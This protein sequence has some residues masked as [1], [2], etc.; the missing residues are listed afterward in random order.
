ME[1]KLIEFL[2]RSDGDGSGDGDGVL[3]FCGQEVHMIDG[4]ATLIDSLKGNIAKGRIL[5]SDLTTSAC[6]VAK[7]GGYFAHGD[8]ARNAVRDA[9]RKALDNMPVEEKV[10]SFRSEFPSGTEAYPAARLFEW[11]G[12]L[13]GSCEAGRRAFMRDR[14]LLM[15]SSFTIP[16]FVEMTKDSY[17]G[18]IIKKLT[19]PS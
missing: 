9:T 4:V 7:V 15:E 6:Y 17:G 12:T 13:T 1:K 10:K 14:G 16:Q 8:T 5:H 11:H 19:Q 2:H 3:S 18:E